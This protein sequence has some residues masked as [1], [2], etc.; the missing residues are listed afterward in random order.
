MSD[1]SQNEWTGTTIVNLVK[2]RL[3]TQEADGFSW[4]FIA[5]HHDEVGNR[6]STGPLLSIFLGLKHDRSYLAVS[7]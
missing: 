1:E 6:K 5:G 4:I 7:H 2:Q 3:L